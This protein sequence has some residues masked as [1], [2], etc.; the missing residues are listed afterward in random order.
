M[1]P[2]YN[3]NNLV[4]YSCSYD[5]PTNASIGDPNHVSLHENR[6]LLEM[7]VMHRVSDVEAKHRMEPREIGS[8]GRF[9]F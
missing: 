8:A 3:V 5:G 6:I 7:S 1:G 2:L 9:S 4:M